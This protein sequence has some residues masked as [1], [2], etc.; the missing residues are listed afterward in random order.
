MPINIQCK[1]SSTDGFSFTLEA[2]NGRKYHIVKSEDCLDESTNFTKAC[3]ELIKYAKAEGEIEV[4]I[5]NRNNNR[6]K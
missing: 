5:T 6:V 3:Q 1:N 2:N 4:E